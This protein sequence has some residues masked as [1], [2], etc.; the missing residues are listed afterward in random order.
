[1]LGRPSM[2]DLVETVQVSSR[3]RSRVRLLGHTIFN[4]PGPWDRV[5]HLAT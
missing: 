1:L 4:Q 5:S 3:V 2:K